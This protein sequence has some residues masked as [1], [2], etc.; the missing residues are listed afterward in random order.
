MQSRRCLRRLDA[1]II[2]YG[3]LDTLRTVLGWLGSTPERPEPIRLY[4]LLYFALLVLFLIVSLTY[5]Y[6]I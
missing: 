6:Q 5:L 1:I 2:R 3:I 4:Y